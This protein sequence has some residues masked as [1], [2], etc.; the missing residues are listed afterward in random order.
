MRPR[1]GLLI[2]TTTNN[3]D[4]HR[5]LEYKGLVHEIVVR[6]PTI[7]HGFMGGLKSIIAGRNCSFI[8]VCEQARNEALEMM[9]QQAAELGVNA[10]VGVQ[11]DS[12]DQGGQ[13]GSAEVLCYG[14][15]VVVE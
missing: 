11:Y 5:I 8:I 10:V 6:T 15:A 2:I 1:F 13:S 9:A 14:S 12:A 7:G 4:G 3:I